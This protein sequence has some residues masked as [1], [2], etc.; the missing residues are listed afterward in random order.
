MVRGIRVSIFDPPGGHRQLEDGDTNS[1]DHY[2]ACSDEFTHLL[3]KLDDGCLGL[4]TVGL[5]APDMA[6]RLYYATDYRWPN[7]P[8]DEFDP[9]CWRVGSRTPPLPPPLPTPPSLPA[10]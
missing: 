2:E 9:C 1:A 5:A 6:R 3:L 10:G 4:R 7:A 8:A